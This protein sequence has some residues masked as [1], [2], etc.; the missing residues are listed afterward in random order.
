MDR[1]KR[2]TSRRLVVGVQGRGGK[3]RHGPF[4][5]HGRASLFLFRSSFL[6]FSSKALFVSLVQYSLLIFDFC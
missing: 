4:Y 3:G 6:S 5:G 2:E 1:T